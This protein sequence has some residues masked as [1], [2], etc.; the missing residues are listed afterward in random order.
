[1]SLVVKLMMFK[2]FLQ[3]SMGIVESVIVE[4]VS[5]LRTITLLFYILKNQIEDNQH[6]DGF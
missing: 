4:I 5:I 3:K 2:L 1:M 6:E